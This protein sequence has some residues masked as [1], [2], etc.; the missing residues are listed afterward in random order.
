MREVSLTMERLPVRELAATAAA[1]TALADHQGICGIDFIDVRR[2]LGAG[3]A[4][5]A[6]SVTVPTA[7]RIADAARHAA[8][9]A[10]HRS[11]C[12]EEVSSLLFHATTPPRWPLNQVVEA[13]SWVMDELGQPSHFGWAMNMDREFSDSLRLA[14]ITL[15]GQSTP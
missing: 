1:L 3:G 6:A 9:L 15:T 2:I 14:L 7:V 10:R 12:S 5:G 11:A 8:K 4:A 13:L